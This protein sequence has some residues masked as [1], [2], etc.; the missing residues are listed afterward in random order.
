VEG[1]DGETGSKRQ[2]GRTRHNLNDV[3]REQ[4]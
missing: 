2:L 4:K 1:F 3:E